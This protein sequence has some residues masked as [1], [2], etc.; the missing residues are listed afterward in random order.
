MVGK[1]FRGSRPRGSCPDTVTS[2]EHY[3]FI[4]EIQKSRVRNMLLSTILIRMR[5]YIYQTISDN[6][7]TL[8]DIK[9]IHI[10]YYN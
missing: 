6:D 5:V 1:L 7:R 10:S 8:I 2:N 3:R 4:G 9:L